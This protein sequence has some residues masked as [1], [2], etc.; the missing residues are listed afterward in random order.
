M[1]AL[2]A[3]GRRTYNLMQHVAAIAPS[4]EFNPSLSLCRAVRWDRGRLQPNRLHNRYLYDLLSP[5]GQAHWILV[6][7]LGAAIFGLLVLT[8]LLRRTILKARLIAENLNDVIWIYNV[9][10]D[11]TTF[12][13]PSIE[14]IRGFTVQETLA[15]S[16]EDS[17]CPEF[18]PAVKN[19]IADHLQRFLKQPGAD[20]HSTFEVQQPHKD[21]SRIWVEFSARMRRNDKGQVEIVGVTRNIS[22]RKRLDQFKEDVDRLIR[23]DLR[24]PIAGIISLPETIE[25]DDNLTDEQREILNMIRQLGTDLLNMTELGLTLYKQEQGFY[26][27]KPQPVDL[28]ATIQ[29]AWAT[30]LRVWSINNE[31]LQIR[32]DSNLETPIRVQAEELLL[33]AVFSNLLANAL[34][35]SPKSTPIQLHIRSVDRWVVASIKNSGSVPEST[36]DSFFDKYVTSGKKNGTGLGTY[37]AK[38][39]VE[40]MGGEI[41]MQTDA[42]ST[43]LEFR[44]R[45]A[46]SL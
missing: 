3:G 16:L 33:T 10:L 8:Y 37:S 45:S 12:V 15:E 14:S 11:R 1:A 30:L 13:S 32:T 46:D 42:E 23:H 43:T 4:A 39:M 36:R 44:L 19:T 28:M 41:S 34:E 35:A 18:L 27:F 40:T 20:V 5:V 2:C 7:L 38:L 26:Q 9:D 6:G 17:I 31:L 22:K 29:R 25:D 21:G 24:N